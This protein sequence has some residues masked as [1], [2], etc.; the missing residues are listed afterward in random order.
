MEKYLLVSEARTLRAYLLM[1]WAL[2]AA[3]ASSIVSNKFPAR[4]FC[5]RCLLQG[6]RSLRWDKIA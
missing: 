3:L 1:A 4:M 6:L 5:M 2:M